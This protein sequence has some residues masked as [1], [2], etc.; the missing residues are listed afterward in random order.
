ME[1]QLVSWIIIHWSGSYNRSI[2]KAFGLNTPHFKA[3]S[4]IISNGHFQPDTTVICLDFDLNK[5][6]GNTSV[7]R[8]A[9]DIFFEAYLHR[10]ERK[11]PEL[12]WLS[13]SVALTP[14]M[15]KQTSKTRWWQWQLKYVVFSPQW[16]GEVIPIWRLHIFFKC[17]GST[18][19]YS[20]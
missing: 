4:S 9:G 1:I 19:N 8:V 17:V 2:S 11:K 7:V 6:V 12:S 20:L 18:T 14:W 13:S 15:L 16:I 3:Y 10:I 5:K